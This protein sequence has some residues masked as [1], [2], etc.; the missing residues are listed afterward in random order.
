[1]TCFPGWSHQEK[2]TDNRVLWGREVGI[3]LTRF[4]LTLCTVK[5]SIWVLWLIYSQHS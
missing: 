4:F 1:M 3:K 5:G 2:V